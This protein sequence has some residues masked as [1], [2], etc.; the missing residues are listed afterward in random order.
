METRS[1]S[2]KNFYEREL[3]IEPIKPSADIPCQI[4]LSTKQDCKTCWITQNMPSQILST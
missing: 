4:Y 2:Y 1:I 3:A